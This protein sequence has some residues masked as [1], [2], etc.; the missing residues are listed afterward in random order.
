[1]FPDVGQMTV[2]DVNDD[3]DVVVGLGWTNTGAAAWRYEDSQLQ[4]LDSGGSTVCMPSGKISFDGS[5]VAGHCAGPLVW[6]GISQFDIGEY[7]D[8]MNAKVDMATF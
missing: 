1:P 7:L 5:R 6:I 4:W 3:G 2:S 8:R